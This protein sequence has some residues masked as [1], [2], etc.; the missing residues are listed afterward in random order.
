MSHGMRFRIYATCWQ[1]QEPP[2]LPRWL[3]SF[4]S[5]RFNVHKVTLALS[6]SL[7]VTLTH[8]R[9]HTELRKLLLYTLLCFTLTLRIGENNSWARRVSETGSTTVP[10]EPAVNLWSTPGFPL[11]LRE[12][13][14]ESELSWR[15]E[16]AKETALIYSIGVL[17]KFQR[18]LP[19]SVISYHLTS[20]LSLMLFVADHFKPL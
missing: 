2:A 17:I 4:L 19:V 14:K 15:D 1:M 20:H 3:D 18:C 6:L 12:L 8:S 11:S 10:S 13:V 16:C 7:S 5:G 9:S